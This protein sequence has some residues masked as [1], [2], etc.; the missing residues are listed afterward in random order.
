[1]QRKKKTEEKNGEEESSSEGA[2]RR[3]MVAVDSAGRES[4]T[5]T[6]PCHAQSRLLPSPAGPILTVHGAPP[7]KQR[8]ME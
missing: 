8:H 3:G 6:G 4:D 1:M 7:H 2:R 5:L